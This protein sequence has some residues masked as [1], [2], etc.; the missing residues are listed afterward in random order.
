MQDNIFRKRNKNKINI[1]KYIEFILHGIVEIHT[2]KIA[3]LMFE[4]NIK[5]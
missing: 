5:N 3:T 2:M 1:M 4:N